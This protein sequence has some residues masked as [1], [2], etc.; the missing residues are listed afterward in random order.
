MELLFPFPLSGCISTYVDCV[1]MISS[2][3]IT[4][5][6]NDLCFKENANLAVFSLCTLKIESH[7]SDEQTLLHN[8]I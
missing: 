3:H 2:V 6:F 5:E 4:I 8:M 1:Y 7:V